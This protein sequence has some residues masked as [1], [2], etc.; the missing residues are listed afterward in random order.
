MKS[1]EF[2]QKVRVRVVGLHEALDS[3]T[4]STKNEQADVK[5]EMGSATDREHVKLLKIPV[6]KFNGD[7]LKFQEWWETYDAAVHSNPTVN[8][9]MKFNYLRGYLEGTAASAI[10]GISLSGKNYTEAIDLLKSRFGNKQA[11][12]S[13]HVDK[14]LNLPEDVQSDD[15]EELREM[16]DM[17]EVNVRS[18]K[19]LNVLTD[20]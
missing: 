9:T 5:P 6:G 8:N 1:S 19:S 2:H 18:L 15:V 10:A 11:L 12:I 4:E 16:Y 14:F 17:I 7:H 3:L 20:H 13:D